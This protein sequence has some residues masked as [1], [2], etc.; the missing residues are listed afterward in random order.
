MV[1]APDIGARRNCTKQDPRKT[2]EEEDQD[3]KLEK[4][5]IIYFWSEVVL[6]LDNK[7]SCSRI[8]L[9]QC[10]MKEAVRNKEIKSVCE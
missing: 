5:G 7:L 4:T 9:Q 8:I 6:Q 3:K 1:A 10:K 2:D